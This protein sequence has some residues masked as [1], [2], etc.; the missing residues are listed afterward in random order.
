MDLGRLGESKHFTDI[1]SQV[2]TL[3]ISATCVVVSQLGFTINNKVSETCV[4]DLKKGN[5]KF[6]YNRICSR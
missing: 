6:L 2:G 5:N 1:R 3:H 4:E